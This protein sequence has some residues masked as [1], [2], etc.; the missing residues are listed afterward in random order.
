MLRCEGGWVVQPKMTL[1][2]S[3]SPASPLGTLLGCP[4]FRN[5][6]SRRRVRVFTVICT[7]KS[8]TH[9][10]KPAS[11]GAR[12][13]QRGLS[14]AGHGPALPEQSVGSISPRE[15]WSGAR[16]FSLGG[17]TGLIC[18]HEEVG[19]HSSGTC[20]YLWPAGSRVVSVGHAGTHSASSEAAS[21]VGK[22]WL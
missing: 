16:F 15:G 14:G 17:L 22:D 8:L 5:S 3:A 11:T 20:Q 7:G 6:P 4:S 13:R 12:G 2:A 18:F 21:C 9:W 1:Q 19:L 10:K